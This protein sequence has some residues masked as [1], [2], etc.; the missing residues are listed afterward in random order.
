MNIWVLSGRLAKDPEIKENEGKKLLSISIANKDNSYKDDKGEWIDKVTF[1][2]GTL[3][4]L[5]PAKEEYL[6]KYL[7]KGMMVTVTGEPRSNGYINSEGKLI[8]SL[9]IKID[10]LEF[11][12][13][14]TK[15][16]EE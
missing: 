16:I 12:T 15:G 4:N 11:D 14:A 13:K 6:K 8:S 9:S 10:K 3:W 5:T 2:S 1:V 7:Q